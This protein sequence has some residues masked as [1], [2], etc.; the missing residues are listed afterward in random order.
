M[1]VGFGANEVLLNLHNAV[2]LGSVVWRLV[3]CDRNVIS[4]HKLLA[5]S[6]TILV[7]FSFQ[8]CIVVASEHD[9]QN[10]IFTVLTHWL[11]WRASSE[12]QFLQS[13]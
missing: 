5:Q 10:V 9:A 1:A 8:R 3:T 4:G 6:R 2:T 7:P 11:I 12:A 13:L